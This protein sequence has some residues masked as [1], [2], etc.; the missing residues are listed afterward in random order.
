MSKK[1]FIELA[2]CLKQ[3]KPVIGG[4]DQS[5]YSDGH[6]AGRMVMWQHIVDKLADFCQ[7][8]NSNFMRDRWLGYINGENG[9]SGG[10]VASK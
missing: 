2:D 4:K 8:Q 7:S 9:K 5:L 6:D 3:S 1:H 10:K